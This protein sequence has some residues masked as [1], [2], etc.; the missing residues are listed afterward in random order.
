MNRLATIVQTKAYEV[1]FPKVIQP[2]HVIVEGKP[3]PNLP[4]FNQQA[5]R[6][7]DEIPKILETPDFTTALQTAIADMN[8]EA[9]EGGYTAID[10]G[11]DLSNVNAIW[12]TR[13]NEIREK[14]LRT[15][16]ACIG[17][18]YSQLW[19]KIIEESRLLKVTGSSEIRVGGT[20][21]KIPYK[22]ALLSDPK[23]Y[24]IPAKSMTR[25]RALEIANLS[26]YVATEGRLSKKYRLTNLL[27]VDD[28]EGEIRQQ[29]IEKLR[30][31]YP[32]QALIYT[33]EQLANEIDGKEGIEADLVEM[34]FDE[35]L[36]KYRELKMQQRMAQMPGTGQPCKQPKGPTQAMS[37][38]AARG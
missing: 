36:S 28:V 29:E 35:T 11:A 21:K 25:N 33:A 3:P 7:I 31:I 16:K 23:T 34:K 27:Y 37:A 20:G 8:Q 12:I 9:Q 6:L 30:E 38:V 19:R 18:F 13:V 15:S 17:N 2:K 26:E 22:Q 4:K 14:Q 32:E 1:L 5:E 24:N 10:I